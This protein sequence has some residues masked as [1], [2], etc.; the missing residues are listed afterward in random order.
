M[1]EVRLPW[2][3]RPRPYQRPVWEYLS[4]GGK[5]AVPCW[6]R[7]AG[8]DE[9]ALH[10]T[11][12]A[13]HERVGSYWYM[14]PQANQARKA[15]WDAVNPRTGRRRIDDVFPDEVRKAV[16]ND[17]MFIEFQNGSTFQLVG[18]DNYNSLVGSPPVGLIFSEYA[19]A[20]PSAWAYLMPIVEENDG[21][22]IFPSTPRG[23]NHF[24][25]LSVSAQRQPGWFF[26]TLTAERSGVFGA[27]QLERIR[28]TLHDQY[29]ADFGEAL[30][31]QEYFVSFDAAIPGAIWADCIVRAEREGR[32][33]DFEIDRTVPVN[34]AWDLGR[35]DDT[36]IWFNQVFSSQIDVFDHHSSNMKDIQFYVELLIEKKKRYGIQYGTHWLPHDARPRTLAAGGK[37]ILQQFEEA[38]KRF[39]LG[40]FRIAPRLDRQE[41]IQAARATFP[42]CRF[43]ATECENGLN[44]LKHYHREWDE[45]KKVFV[46]NPSHDWSSHDSDSFRMLSITWKFAK[47][48]APER[49]LQDGLI[50]RS[51]AGMNF[52]DLKV[53]HFKRMKRRRQAALT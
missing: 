4:A 45:E 43:H 7:R 34:T 6:H 22:V 1:S 3:W 19:V 40:K 27:E 48:G 36:S 15:M 26:E 17:E 9:V 8:K 31:Q 42:W 41:G 2:Q 46:D 44:S 49:P 51:V 11:A 30:F 23:K 52:G 37:S 10:H 12:C 16:R 29:G 13:A 18:S 53:K 25:A 38:A 35:T 32:V 47:D 14:L 21:W 50:E 24:H 20:N 39:G 5:R 28:Q 33:L